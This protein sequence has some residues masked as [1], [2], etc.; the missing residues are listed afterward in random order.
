MHQFVDFR[1]ARSLG[2][3]TSNRDYM[4]ALLSWY[5]QWRV[6]DVARALSHQFV[7]TPYHEYFIA[8]SL[9]FVSS[10]N[11]AFLGP[12]QSMTLV[13]WLLE[14][15]FGELD[16]PEWPLV[17]LYNQECWPLELLRMANL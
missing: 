1:L 14:K 16:H 3:E 17:Q 10:E 15:G 11:L 12:G 6:C 5:L 4:D 7:Q 2:I 13:Q 8:E 9:A